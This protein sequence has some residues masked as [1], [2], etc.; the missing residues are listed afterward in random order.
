[1]SLLETIII[2]FNYVEITNS[3]ITL[4]L[5]QF[6][7][8]KLKVHGYIS[9][10]I[11]LRWDGRFRIFQ[12]KNVWNTIIPH[13]HHTDATPMCFNVLISKPQ[14]PTRIL[15]IRHREALI[16][17]VIINRNNTVYKTSDFLLLLKSIS[18]VI[19][20]AL[21]SCA[22]SRNKFQM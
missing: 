15:C 7:W 22:A 21:T 1:M 20:F 3:K 16:A 10:I 14:M 5:I 9:Y 12:K 4:L 6:I 2:I 8:Y 17:I 13:P 11:F 18:N 19:C